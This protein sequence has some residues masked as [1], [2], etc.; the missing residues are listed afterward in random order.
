MVW[1]NE[2]QA[3]SLSF[4]DCLQRSV[5]ILFLK[6]KKKKF[7]IGTFLVVQCL[8]FCLPMQGIW[9]YSW[10][11]NWGPTYHKDNKPEGCNYWSLHG[12]EPVLHNKRSPCSEIRERLVHSDKDPVETKIISYLLSCLT[13]KEEITIN[14]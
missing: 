11:G 14:S 8:S 5:H 3:F 6:K 1:W 9:F 4:K 2:Q 12:L 13:H 10:S 7:L